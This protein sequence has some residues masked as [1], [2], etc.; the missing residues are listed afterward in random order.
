LLSKTTDY[1]FISNPCKNTKIQTLVAFLLLFRSFFHANYA[2]SGVLTAAWV[3]VRVRL[4]KILN[5][6][7]ADNSENSSHLV[8]G[9]LVVAWTAFN[10]TTSHH[11]GFDEDMNL[12]LI[13]KKSGKALID[14]VIS[15]LF[16]C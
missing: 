1:K 13:A 2:N 7:P 3:F 5:G 10:R 8:S 16:P 14:S 6:Y 12:L 11:E 9:K 4:L 15:T